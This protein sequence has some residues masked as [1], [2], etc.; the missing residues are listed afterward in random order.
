MTSFGLI[1]AF[2][3]MGWAVGRSITPPARRET[4]DDFVRAA[5]E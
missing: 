2:V 3:I 4:Q 5:A 1:G